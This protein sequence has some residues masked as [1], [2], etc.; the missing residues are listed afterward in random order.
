MLSAA[1]I[2][3]AVIVVMQ[4]WFP[5]YLAEQER[6]TGMR[7]G[8][9]PPPE[10]YINRNS[11]ETLEGEQMPKIVVMAEGLSGTPGANGSHVYRATWNVGVGV[12]T[13]AK[14]EEVCN[15]MVKAYGAAVRALVLNKMGTQNIIGVANVNWTQ[16]RYP[17]ITIPSPI[18][19]FKAAN[20][21]FTMDVEDVV[22]KYGGPPVPSRA[23][24]P[25]WPEVETVDI[26][27]DIVPDDTVFPTS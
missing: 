20:I 16:E 6:Q 2:E 24:P 27:T 8:S 22:H 4:T 17:S 23:V 9:L 26:E 18:Q 14:T 10:N 3:D 21:S 19:L 13:A 12:A 5:T 25:P 15:R 1:T 11:F 7:A